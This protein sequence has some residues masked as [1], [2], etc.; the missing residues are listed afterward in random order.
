MVREDRA[1][2]IGAAV[3]TGGTA[4]KAVDVAAAVAA[5]ADNAGDVPANGADGNAG[6]K[7][8]V[9]PA[10]PGQAVAEITADS[11]RPG[12]MFRCSKSVCSP[13]IS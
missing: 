5:A 13:S 12:L 3:P 7:E 6:M 8:Q 9:A 1:R 2:E 4:D 10:G 11:L